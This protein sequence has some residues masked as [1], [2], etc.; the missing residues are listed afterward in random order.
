LEGNFFFY[1]TFFFS[2]FLLGAHLWLSEC[3][4]FWA[5]LLE[6][7][8]LWVSPEELIQFGRELDCLCRSNCK[9]AFVDNMWRK[10]DEEDWRLG[11][12]DS[13]NAFKIIFN[14]YKLVYTN[15]I[16]TYTHNCFFTIRDLSCYGLI[17][18]FLVFSKQIPSYFR[19]TLALVYFMG[20]IQI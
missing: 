1:C 16:Y 15:V 6:F 7:F 8:Y 14:W 3:C 20:L 17:S 5:F 11:E 4:A 13:S 18:V 12:A 9:F 2:S 10:W 19:L